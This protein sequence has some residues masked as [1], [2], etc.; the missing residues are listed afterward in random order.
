MRK[1]FTLFEL[2]IIIAIIAVLASILTPVFAQAKLSAFKSVSRSNLRQNGISFILYSDDYG[3]IDWMPPYQAARNLLTSATTCDQSDYWPGGCQSQRSIP[4]IGS[5]GYM[6]AILDK[7]S[8]D[9]TGARWRSYVD[10][11]EHPLLLMAPFYASFRVCPMAMGVEPDRMLAYATACKKAGWTPHMPDR[12]L[13]LGTDGSV[14][15][16]KLGRHNLYLSDWVCATVYE[17][18]ISK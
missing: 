13:A 5:Y 17:S 3:G 12:M 15:D 9:A 16:A 14:R 2:L 10:E 18:G 6:P 4:M 8:S 7:M 1:G 11:R